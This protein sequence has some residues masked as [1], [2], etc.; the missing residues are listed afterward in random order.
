MSIN[1]DLYEST[2][3]NLVSDKAKHLI[4]WQPNWNFEESVEKTIN[5][6]KKFNSGISV[7]Q[8]CIDDLNAFGDVTSGS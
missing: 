5:W 7:L 6:Y 3:L 4:H 8:C 1:S 2:L